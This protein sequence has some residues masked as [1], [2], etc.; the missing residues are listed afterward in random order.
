ML[1]LWNRGINSNWRCSKG[2]MMVS[3][4]FHFLKCVE[5]SNELTGTW[6]YWHVV[7]IHLL[8]SQMNFTM[9]STFAQFQLGNWYLHSTFNASAYK[10]RAPKSKP[11]GLAFFFWVRNGYGLLYIFAWK[12]SYAS[13]LRC[14][15]T[16]SIKWCFTWKYCT[17]CW[18][19][20]ENLK[21]LYHVR[22]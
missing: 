13:V 5:I 20:F 10:S 14:L 17:M 18:E 4:N 15:V 8:K 11:F 21:I 7:W 3:F 22:E 1:L 6:C 16:F 2:S 19:Q 12:F 9:V